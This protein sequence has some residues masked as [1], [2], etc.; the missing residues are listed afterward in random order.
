MLLALESQRQKFQK[1]IREME[2]KLTEPAVKA[3]YQ[4]VEEVAK[5]DKL[6]LVFE[7]S[8]SPVIYAANK[9]NLDKKVIQLYNKKFPSKK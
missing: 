3:I 2:A 7:V 9:K 5:K 6:D 1:E 8:A 4:I